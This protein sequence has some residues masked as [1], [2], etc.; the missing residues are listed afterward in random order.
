VR[1][2]ECQDSAI[3]ACMTRLHRVVA[4]GVPHHLT[5]RGNARQFIL[6]RDEDRAVYMKLL[7]ENIEN[8]KV[9]LLGYCLM[10][11][12]V[13]L[14]AVP[15]LPDG[16]ALAFRNAHGRYATYWNAIHGAS[17]HAWQGR[18][19]SCPLDEEH[20][21][22]ALR[23]T[24]L[25]PVRAGLVSEPESWPWSSAAVHCG[26]ASVP[27]LLTD[28]LWQARWTVTTW[29]EYLAAS[30][31]ESELTAIR[32]CTHTGR[33]L[34][35]AEFVSAL[36]KITGRRLAPQKKG[37]QMGEALDPR[38]ASLPLNTPRVES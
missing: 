11:N 37:R 6:N 14:I 28:I 22:A 4:V 35:D 16:L 20:L 27:S 26:K 24:E 33:P 23:Y 8:Y 17:G 2:L 36:E 25:N 19:Y 9:S 1:L 12:H 29:R 3:V 32:R 30:E 21:W 15:A 10:S 34:G 13:H 5:Q 31:A 18:F 38:Q 7:R